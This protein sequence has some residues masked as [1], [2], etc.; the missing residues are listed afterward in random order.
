MISTKVICSFLSTLA[1]SQVAVA[2][3][4]AVEVRTIGSE[5]TDFAIDAHGNNLNHSRW[6]DSRVRVSSEFELLGASAV[7]EFDILS[8]QLAG[9]E[10]L[11]GEGDERRRSAISLQGVLPRK[12]AISGVSGVGSWQVGLVTSDWGLGMV[13][14]DGTR[15]NWFGYSEFGDRV[16][17]LRLTS[18]PFGSGR[19]AELP[20]YV[21]AAVDQVLSDDMAD[22]LGDGSSA[23]Q[24]LGSALWKNSDKAVGI[25]AV[26]RHQVE[27]SEQRATD[28]GM[29]DFFFD[30]P[31]VNLG[32]LDLRLSG[33]G[34]VIG[35]QTDRATTYS[36]RDMVQV[37][38]GGGVGRLELVAPDDRLT[39]R[40][41]AGWASGDS[42]PDD[43]TTSDFSFDRDFEVGAV[44][45][46]QFMAG[47]EVGTF[48]LLSDPQYSG[49]PPDGV[50]TVTTE[51]A[52]RRARFEQLAIKAKPFESNQNLEVRTGVTRATATAPISQPFYSF[53]AGGT[54]MTHHNEVS[55][56]DALG[57]EL[58]WAL[59]YEVSGGAI[60][61]EQMEVDLEVQGGHL[62]LSDDLAGNGEPRIDLYTVSV[63]AGF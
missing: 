22:L 20:L 51:G 16:I 1:L 32:S 2:G 63:T 3:E 42:N 21:T 33:E 53:R 18:T 14:N 17:R 57:V 10:W 61:L 29:I 6:V 41:Q 13:A 47:V 15:D 54:P 31:I 35:G 11:H 8:G 23:T 55:T 27:L 5:L 60:G 50:E 49:S 40:A 43:G 37:L 24:V 38:S 30:L 52:F 56:G 39:L 7:A 36:S 45:F 59:S 28:A 9:D 4:S 46:D 25:Y 58:D 62:F 19:E 48:G 12:L 26:M 34:A 44:L